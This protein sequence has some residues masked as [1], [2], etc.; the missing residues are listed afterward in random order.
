MA[1]DGLFHAAS[2]SLMMR[3]PARAE[4]LVLL[5]EGALNAPRAKALNA[6]G[7]RWGFSP[8]VTLAAAEKAQGRGDRAGARMRALLTEL[9]AL[10]AN[11]VRSW[12]AS[13]LR[14]DALAIL[15]D[16][17]GAMKALEQAVGLGWRR[18]YHVRRTPHFTR[19]H[20]RADFQELL[21]RVDGL[22]I[23]ER[24]RYEGAR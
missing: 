18:T 13:S 20:E 17:D 14:A 5:A 9:Q 1:A 22:V 21:A 11:G 24:R 15:D 10:E 8:E 3:D 4:R 12:G 23:A 16:P 7:M 2:L 19:F 6:T